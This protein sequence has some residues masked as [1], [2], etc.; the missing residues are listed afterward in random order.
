MFV[1]QNGCTALILASN[2]GHVA[3]VKVLL[4]AECAMEAKDKVSGSLGP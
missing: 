1:I 4:D 3:V 2:N